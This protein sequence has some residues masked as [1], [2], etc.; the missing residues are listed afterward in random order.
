MPPG[1]GVIY[2]YDHG[3]D[4]PMNSSLKDRI[5][6][7]KV[8]REG[9]VASGQAR[10]GGHH[11]APRSENSTDTCWLN[12]VTFLSDWL[13]L[14]VWVYRVCLCAYAAPS[15]SRLSGGLHPV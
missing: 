3:S 6:S 15:P 8:S 1:V 4:V 12:S 9:K 10:R 2:L 5:S 13:T 11:P 7:G 14:Q